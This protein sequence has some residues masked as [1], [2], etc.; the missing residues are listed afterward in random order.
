MGLIP[1]S[2]R[3]PEELRAMTRKGGKRSGV[4]RRAKKRFREAVELL[5]RMDCTDAEIR[6]QLEAMGIADREMTN[7][8]ALVL[9]MFRKAMTGDVQAFNTLRDT[10]GEKPKEQSEVVQRV[11]LSERPLSQQEARDFM[12]KLEREI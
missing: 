7:Q 3:T 4:V 6:G 2:E 1:N 5:L 11:Q 9:S 10:A 12:N 8:M